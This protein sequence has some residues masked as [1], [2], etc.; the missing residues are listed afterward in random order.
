NK[1]AVWS[2][3]PSPGT[4]PAG[5]RVIAADDFD[6]DGKPDVAWQS[7]GA[8]S[9]VRV[10]KMDGATIAQD[11]NPI[12]LGANLNGQVHHISAI[13]N[14][15]GSG[16]KDLLS[17]QTNANLHCAL[18]MNGGAPPAWSST[19][20]LPLVPEYDAPVLSS[21]TANQH[22][23]TVNWSD[24]SYETGYDIYVKQGASGS[25]QYAKSVAANSTQTTIEDL[26]SETEYFVQVRANSSAGAIGSIPMSVTT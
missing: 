5:W 25:W 1:P 24:V 23:A 21:V 15:D 3:I 7:R 19:G 4:A 10:W 20:A 9:Q 12:S 17:R 18:Y 13:G 22:T 8:N 2:G 6:G 11:Y 14:I 16:T 26:Q